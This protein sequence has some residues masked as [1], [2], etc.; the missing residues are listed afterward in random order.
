MF[1]TSYQWRIYADPPFDIKSETARSILSTT[2]RIPSFV[3]PPK[4]RKK[5]VKSSAVPTQGVGQRKNTAVAASDSSDEFEHLTVEAED[6]Y[7]WNSCSI[8]YTYMFFC[9]LDR[10][11]EEEVFAISDNEMEED[12]DELALTPSSH[13]TGPPS[14]PS[15][16]KALFVLFQ[17]AIFYLFTNTWSY[18]SSGKKGVTS[19]DKRDGEGETMVIPR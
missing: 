16:V 2:V 17:L 14:T 1:I 3:M 6:K 18:D 10:I 8:F 4:N 13:I 19:S 7:A 9:F 12:D 5:A 11:D 15:P